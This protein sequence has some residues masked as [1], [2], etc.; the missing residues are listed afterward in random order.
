MV[1]PSFY[2]VLRFHEVISVLL[3]FDRARFL[4]SLQL[5]RR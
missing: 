1:L 3:G 4:D 5:D 2:K